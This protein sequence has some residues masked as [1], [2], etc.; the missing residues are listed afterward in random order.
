[1]GIVELRAHGAA[2]ERGRAGPGDFEVDALRVVLGT[3]DVKGRV[4]SDRL[5]AEDVLA[6]GDAGGDG[7]DP[8][9]VVGDHVVGCPCAGRVGAVNETGL[10]DLVE[11]EL[12]LVDG[13]A[14]VTAGSKV[15][16]HRTAVGLGPIAPLEFQGVSGCHAH[17]Y[18]A[19]GCSLVADDVRGVV[20]ADEAIVLVLGDGPTSDDWGRVLILEA[21][22][23]AGVPLATSDDAGHDAVSRHFGNK[24]EG[25]DQGAR[26]DE[27]HLDA[28]CR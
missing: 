1:M 3:A 17:V 4:Q 20:V 28:M 16:D 9:V 7:D 8:R 2:G 26:S 27:R 24:G 10:V 23:V 5:V 22:I 18:A 14:V 15:V 6:R 11:L 13:G 19:W 12:A 25:P 21:R